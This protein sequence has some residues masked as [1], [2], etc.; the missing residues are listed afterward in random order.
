MFE[1]IKLLL[2]QILRIPPEP[3]DPMGDVGSVRVFRAAKSYYRYK[4][5][6]WVLGSL[7]GVVGA[8]VLCAVISAALF[9]HQSK[10]P[11]SINILLEAV[12][13]IVIVGGVLFK[14][15][16]GY[17]LVRLDYE[18]RWY[19][20]SDRSLRIREGIFT[21]KEMTMTFANI[22]NISIVQGPLQRLF[23]ISDLKVDS[24]GGGA[25]IQSHAA[26]QQDASA[27]HI[28]Y[29]RGVDNPTEIMALMR[30][31]LKGV[32]DTGLGHP[33]DAHAPG[34]SASEDRIAVLRQALLEASAL[35]KALELAA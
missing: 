4:L 31:R 32:Q 29:F 2:C 15:A 23:G 21:V 30:E 35:R 1:A 24:A 11:L 17:F 3:H 14:V 5:L 22:Q 6:G 27:P 8:I 20:L 33:E 18:M 9:S 34:M 12:A 16:T 19:K 26:G 7:A 10:A 13:A 25:V 28:A